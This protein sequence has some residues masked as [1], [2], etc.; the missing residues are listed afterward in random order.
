MNRLGGLLQHV[1]SV[2][3]RYGHKGNSLR[4]ITNL[5]NESGGFLDNFVESVFT[6]LWKER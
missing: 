6:P 2:P 4:V 5:L 1:I 3:A